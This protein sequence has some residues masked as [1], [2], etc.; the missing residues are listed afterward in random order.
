[1][2]NVPVRYE[3][4]G[5]KMSGGFGRVELFRDLHLDRLVA[6]K[7]ISDEGERHRVFDEIRALLQL[8][9]K[10]VVQVYDV[11]VGDDG[12]LG[13]VEEFIDGQDLVESDR[14]QLSPIEYLKTLWQI[15]S[16]IADCH[17]SGIIHRDIKPNNIKYDSEGVVK[18]FDFGL[19]KVVGAGAHTRGF[20]GTIGFAAPEQYVAGTV[21][22]TPAVD[23]WAFGVMATYLTNKKLAP[24]FSKPTNV[25]LSKAEIAALPIALPADIVDILAQC[26][27]ENPVNRP[28]ISE[29]RDVIAKHLLRD[30]HQALA[31]FQGSARVLNAG[32][33]S[34]S[35]ELPSIGMVKISY[36]GLSFLIAAVSGEVLINNASVTAGECLPGACVIALGEAHRK[37]NRVFVTFDLSNPEVVI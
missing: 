4:T 2:I 9:S 12:E 22:L 1:M 14:P 6:I 24:V 30:Q 19:S 34:V 10:H 28:S 31:V 18:L 8:R 11:L 29:I 35:M 7:F 36:D 20:K 5:K 16:G 27:S 37:G 13:I 23:V 21:V 15:A 17:A 33:R 32:S 3:S 25:G 26:F